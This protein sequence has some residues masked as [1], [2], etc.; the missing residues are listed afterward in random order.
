V[1]NPPTV[2]VDLRALVP[3]PTG[4]GV[5]TRELLSFLGPAGT[6]RYRGFAH[7]ELHAEAGLEPSGVP[8]EVVPGRLGVLWQQWHLPRRLARGDC[9][10]LWSPLQ[11][12]PSCSP[13]PG[14]VTV[15][16]LTVLLLPDAHTWKVRW[17]QVPFLEG[18]L[19]RARRVVA[20]SQATA[21]DLRFHFPGAFAGAPD[22]LRV[23]HPGVRASFTSGTEEQ[24][25]AF[26]AELGCP[27]GYFLF[28]GTLEPRKNVGAVVEAWA[29]L[30]S[31]NP[32]TLPLVLAGG[33]GWHS[34]TLARRIEALAPR[35]LL[36]LGRVDDARLLRLLQGA[37]VFVYP[38]FYEGFG[39]PVIEAMA[40]GVPV[41]TSDRSSLPEV[42][43]GA[44]LL[45]PPDDLGLLAGALSH[46]VAEPALAAELGARGRERAKIFRWDAAA[47]AMEEVFREAL[48]I[49]PEEGR[50]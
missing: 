40:C 30:K 25:A 38:S 22:K 20:V 45:V 8:V 5:Y 13:L 35:G 43:G 47:V 46:L 37:T 11:T 12:L 29:A 33:L 50:G 17:S 49:G 16:D 32:R 15:H 18:S 1:L 44:A 24:I 42:A 36:A 31:E 2:A 27:D 3:A 41:V 4:I 19:D 21:D 23:I 39:L 48:L 10:L 34:R 6:L 14:V 28:A 26:R 9:D 7:R